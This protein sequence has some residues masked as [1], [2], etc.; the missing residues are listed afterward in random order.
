M[1]AFSRRAAVEVSIISQCDY[2]ATCCSSRHLAIFHVFL[3]L[4]VLPSSSPS[5]NRCF[6]QIT[7]KNY[8]LERL[9]LSGWGWEWSSSIS[10]SSE[11]T[12]LQ[13]Q[14]CMARQG[15]CYDVFATH[16]KHST[17]PQQSHAAHCCKHL[18]W[19][20]T[21]HAWAWQATSIVDN[22]LY[23]YPCTHIQMSVKRRVYRAPQCKASHSHQLMRGWFL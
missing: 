16:L 7:K 22:F 23:S 11:W 20:G 17:C 5:L 14:E 15:Q 12:I 6:K 21:N 4:S 8:L 10:A 18:N 3:L 9:E 19:Q 1:G 13:L 2:L